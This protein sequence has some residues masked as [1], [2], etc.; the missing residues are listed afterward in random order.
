MESMGSGKILYWKIGHEVMS[1][2]SIFMVFVVAVTWKYG[3]AMRVYPN[4]SGDS[5]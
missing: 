2:R 1:F 3:P 4:I 5:L